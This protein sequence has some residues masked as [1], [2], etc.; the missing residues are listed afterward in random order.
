MNEFLAYVWI[1]VADNLALSGLLRMLLLGIGT[2][3]ARR[4]VVDALGQEESVGDEDGGHANQD[5]PQPL[6]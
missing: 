5:H 3:V 4:S 2:P 6:P 1:N